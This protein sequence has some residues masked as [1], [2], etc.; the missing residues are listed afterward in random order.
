MCDCYLHKCKFCEEKLPVH[1]GNFETDR[2]E[3]EVFCEKHI[4]DHNVFIFTVVK[5]FNEIDGLSEEDKV[6]VFDSITEMFHHYLDR[7]KDKVAAAMEEFDKFQAGE[8]KVKPRKKNI[9]TTLPKR[10]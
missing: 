2:S 10:K 9:P 4:P 8:K 6:Y 5:V 1:L 7:S 3:I